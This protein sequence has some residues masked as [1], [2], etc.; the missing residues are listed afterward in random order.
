VFFFARALAVA[1]GVACSGDLSTDVVA[2]VASSA[3][4]AASPA[5]LNGAGAALPRTGDC[6]AS[7]VTM[8]VIPP[9]AA[10]LTV[11]S[12]RPVVAV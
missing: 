10:E 5:Y 9:A 2:R 8:G 12:S 7:S 4:V 6:V 1:P 11:C 3:D